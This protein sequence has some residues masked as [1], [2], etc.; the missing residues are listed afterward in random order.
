MG[1]S[2][3]APRAFRTR[4]T[5]AL[6]LPMHAGKLRSFSGRTARGRGFIMSNLMSCW[7]LESEDVWRKNCDSIEGYKWVKR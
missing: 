3:L 7:S 5:Y 2:F 1:R 4:A 6:F